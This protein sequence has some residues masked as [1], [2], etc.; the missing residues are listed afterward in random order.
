MRFCFKLY[1]WCCWPIQTPETMEDVQ[2]WHTTYRNAVDQSDILGIFNWYEFRPL[3]TG[4]VI[5]TL[6]AIYSQHINAMD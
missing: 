1:A 3:L 5:Q 4:G 2:Q 6:T